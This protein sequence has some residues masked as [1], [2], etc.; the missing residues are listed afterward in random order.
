MEDTHFSI[1]FKATGWKEKLT[2][3][4]DKHIN[5]PNKE[6]ITKVAGK[7]AGYGLTCKCLLLAGLTILRE[8]DK[9]PDA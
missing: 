4:S 8:S 9:M 6:L 2:E 3:L 7:N 1:T 5:P